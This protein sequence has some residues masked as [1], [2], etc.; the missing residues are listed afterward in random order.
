MFFVN[1]NYL[2]LFCESH[3]SVST[4]GFW[5]PGLVYLSACGDSYRCFLRDRDSVLATLRFLV[6]SIWLA[7]WKE[8]THVCTHTSILMHTTSVRGCGTRWCHTSYQWWVPQPESPWLF[9]MLRDHVT[10]IL[11]GDFFSPFHFFFTFFLFF[12][13]FCEAKL[14]EI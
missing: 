11:R 2:T 3:F 7:D 12:S 9:W 10:C 8:C 6:A 5:S 14:F 1:T 13:F 4:E